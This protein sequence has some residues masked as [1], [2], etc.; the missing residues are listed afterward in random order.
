MPPYIQYIS[1]WP[2]RRC[3]VFL[4]ANVRQITTTP[5]MNTTIVAKIGTKTS[6]SSQAFTQ[7]G[8]SFSPS[9][10]PG[11]GAIVPKIAEW[12][13]S[14]YLPL[15]WSLAPRTT[16]TTTIAMM[17]TRIAATT[18][19]IRFRCDRMIF[20]VCSGVREPPP[21]SRAGAIVPEMQAPCYCTYRFRI[22]KGTNIWITKFK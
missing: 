2:R 3:G 1:F 14:I 18:G 4:R 17:M 10:L 13:V 5:T 12:L 15:W 16:H 11:N 8:S 9:T 20:R 6:G 19:T 7:G 21:T 22:L